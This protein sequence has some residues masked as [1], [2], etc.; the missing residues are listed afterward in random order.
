M[1]ILRISLSFFLVCSRN[2]NAV[3]S[4]RFIEPNSAPSWNITP[5]SVRIS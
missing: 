2:G 5:N 4:Y 3:L 1:T